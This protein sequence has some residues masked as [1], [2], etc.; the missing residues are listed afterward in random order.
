MQKLSPKKQ[1]AIVRQYLGGFSYDE[2]ASR[3][4]ASKGTVA[5][6]I[7]DLK[8]GR[9][10]EASNV[11]EQLELLRELAV[12]LRRFKL[13]PS[14]AAAG[15]AVLSHLQ[16]LGV[17][18][19]DIEPWAAVC[20]QLSRD[21]I[22]AQAFIKAA[23]ALEQVRE[24]TGLSPE[25]LETKVHGLEETVVRLEP[26]AKELEGCRE[27]LEELGKRRQK[28]V[29]EITKLEKR[30]Q[31]LSRDVAQKEQREAELSHRVQ[32]LEQRAQAADER[33]ATARRDL[34]A[35]A[36]L[37]LSLEDLSVFVQRLGGVAQ[38]HGVGSEALRD[39]LLHELE[40]LEEGLGLEG[41]IEVKQREVA[42]AERGAVKAWEEQSALQAAIK[43]LR[44]E[45]ARLHADMA[46]ERKHVR[47]EVRAIS[48]VVR[49][50]ATELRREM[51]SG[52]GEALAEVQKL[53]DQALKL[54]QEVGHIE[55][56][57]EANPWFRSLL[58]LAKGDAGVSADEARLVGLVVLR[59]LLAWLERNR[60]KV[61]T[62]SASLGE[63]ARIIIRELERWNL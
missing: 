29:D 14:Q 50:G 44:Q 20:R 61:P 5:N 19:A 47:K 45:Q 43:K 31:P 17:E 58:A 49:E 9:F 63:C 36:G 48:A 27:Q 24:R 16:T 26:L 37:G 39:R 21:E 25:A 1:L 54:G 13:T 8:A 10:P 53:R 51:G 32:E 4:G 40:A 28:L 57:I 2:I 12:D 59:G 60:D 38:R 41:L 62:T 22:E 46:V 23:L 3:A 56:D 6:I 7:S 11:S 15:L 34:Q 33:L 52:V 18:P 30:H 35:L 42:E 55:A